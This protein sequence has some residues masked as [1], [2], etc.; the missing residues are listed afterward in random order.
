MHKWIV[1][2][3]LI[4]TV[5]QGSS[6][7]PPMRFADPDRGAKLAT[8]F[9]DIDRLFAEFAKT[10]HVPAPRGAIIIDGELAHIGRRPA[11]ATSR[12]GAR[13]TRTRSSAS[14]R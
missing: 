6:A 4:A 2:S 10:A 5:A 7:P 3:S 1:V 11:C 12:Q 9:A 14:R 8:A 13:S